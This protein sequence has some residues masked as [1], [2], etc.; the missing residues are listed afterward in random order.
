MVRNSV[1][2]PAPFAPSTAITSSRLDVQ[3]HVAQHGRE[4]VAG[5][6]A[7]DV[8]KVGHRRRFPRYASTTA[9]VLRI[10]SASPSAIFAP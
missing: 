5:G 8:E 6:N 9:G 1:V 7:L 10:V 2:L 4:P 3:R